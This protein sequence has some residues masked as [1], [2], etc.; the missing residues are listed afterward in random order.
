MA[1][2]PPAGLRLAKDQ[3]P[4]VRA[5][6]MEA[7]GRLAQAE[8]LPMLREGALSPIDKVAEGAVQSL[9]GC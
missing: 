7:L 5:R 4:D 3:K 9:A 8:N 6:A 2:T 1:I